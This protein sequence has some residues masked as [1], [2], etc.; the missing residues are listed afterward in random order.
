MDTIPEPFT[1][2][3]PSGCQALSR[4][5]GFRVP[6]GLK[7]GRV[8]A[9]SEVPKGKACGCICP[10]CHSPLAAKAQE[11]RRKRPHFAHL[12]DTGCQTGRETGIHL[13]AKQLIAE[14]QWLLIPAWT[15]D[16]IDMPNPP[17]ARDAEGRLH[18]GRQIDHPGGRAELRDIE[19]ER[20]FDGY[21]PD[22]YA[23]DEGGELLIEI[24]VTHAVDDSKAARVLAQG[25]RMIEIDLSQMHRDTP[26][27]L[28][29]F[30]E[31]VLQ[32]PANRIWI[33]CPEALKEWR[34][35]K[36]ELDEQVAAR[37]A[38]IAQQ[39]EQLIKAIKARQER[40]AQDSKDKSGRKAWV[41]KKERQKYAYELAQ[42]GELTS[43]QRIERILREYQISAEER[44]SELLNSAPPAV[45]SACLRA[46]ED[47]WIFGVDPAL[48]QLLAYEHF[49][50]KR[51]PGDRFNQRD[52]ASWVRRSFQSEK[53]LYRLFVAQYA[54]RAEARR[55][56]YAKR[57]L[58]SWIFTDEENSRIPDFYVP[59]NDFIDRLEAA[60]VIR[61]LPAPIGECEVLP[62][63]PT[64]C[65]PVAAVDLG[66]VPAATNTPTSPF[67]A[68]DP[69]IEGPMGVGPR[70]VIDLK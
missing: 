52:V 55:A 18:W 24:R 30:E 9:P 5:A 47:A 19:L 11:S 56:G 54:G 41:R 40:D 69:R 22:V 42:L 50:V 16:P 14:R 34:A 13:R 1:L 8:W 37:N 29:A 3:N 38:E 25:R 27:D 28:M 63:P 53:A 20:S 68:P 61:H 2:R 46:H 12:I 62:P 65:A 23:I 21:Q 57:R 4:R 45:R 15:G 36:L 48:W 33:S 64:G 7:D 44:V 66:T 49:A 39:H 31:A 26:H 10:G 35:S 32:E 6:F 58:D 51:A 60:R 59:I 43:P 67:T 17:H 70:Y